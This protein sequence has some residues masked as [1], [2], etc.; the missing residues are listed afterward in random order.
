MYMLLALIGVVL[1]ARILPRS[2]D[3]WVR[4]A[5]SAAYLALSVKRARRR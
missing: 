5:R 3:R 1:A 4:V 2:M